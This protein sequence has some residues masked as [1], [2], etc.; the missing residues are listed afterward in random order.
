M[1]RADKRRDSKLAAKSGLAGP[2][3][4]EAARA[5]ASGLAYQQRGQFQEAAK[6]WD[7]GTRQEL[8]TLVL[9]GVATGNPAMTAR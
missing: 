9:A 5:L 1:N 4:A 3:G 6:L 7:V 2:G 8:L